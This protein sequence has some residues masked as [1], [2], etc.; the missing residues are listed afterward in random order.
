MVIYEEVRKKHHKKKQRKD[1]DMGLLT[2][3]IKT[4]ISPEI[5]G[6]MIRGY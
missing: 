1:N 2:T 3:P 5:A 6:L 4:I